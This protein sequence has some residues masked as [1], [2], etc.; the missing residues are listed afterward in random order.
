MHEGPTSEGHIMSSS[1]KMVVKMKITELYGKFLWPIHRQFIKKYLHKRCQICAASEAFIKLDSATG[2]CEVCASQKMT[3]EKQNSN[4]RLQ[5]LSVELKKRL[6]ENEG[7]GTQDYDAVVLFSGGKDSAF[8]V[9]ELKRLHPKLRLLALLIDTG[10]MSPVALENAAKAAEKLNVD[11][12]AYRPNKEFY[13]KFF[14]AVCI[15]QSL[16]DRGCFQTVDMVEFYFFY[17][18]AKNFA[19]KNQIPLI[20]DGLAWAQCERLSNTEHFEWPA[21]TETKAVE[22]ELGLFLKAHQTQDNE[23]Y[24]WNPKKYKPEHIPKL[25]HPFFVWRFEE[26]EIRKKVTDLNLIK[27]GNDS[28][29]VTNQQVL[30]MMVIV[31]YIRIG[32]CSY[33]PDITMQIRSGTADRRYWQAIFEMSEYI[34]KTGWMM[35]KDIEKIAADLDLTTADLGLPWS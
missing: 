19:A 21:D 12:M 2:H 24:F 20:I 32:Y 34:A 28:P 3:H 30:V 15:D 18:I 16:K 25:I 23:M 31:D 27:S 26:N 13:K 33:E 1:A 7:S 10:F 6:T 4:L 11:Y 29:L 17:S 35:K 8:L 22:K 14:K 5:N 9:W